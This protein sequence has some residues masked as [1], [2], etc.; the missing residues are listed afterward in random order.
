MDPRTRRS[1]IRLAYSGSWRAASMSVA[2]A[3]ESGLCSL[4]ESRIPK[5]L[6]YPYLLVCRCPTGRYAAA[7]RNTTGDRLRNSV[8]HFHCLSGYPDDPN[9][10]RSATYGALSNLSRPV[11][12]TGSVSL[13]PRRL[14]GAVE[15]GQQR[16]WSG[17]YLSVSRRRPAMRRTTRWSSSAA[18]KT[19]AVYDARSRGSKPLPNT[20]WPSV[21]SRSAS[22]PGA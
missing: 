10:C 14:G 3:R 22:I 12:L 1:S 8:S 15:E 16:A 9:W 17:F 2:I 6:C 18:A 4:N 21:V 5:H 19:P 11:R 7:L 13:T 20:R